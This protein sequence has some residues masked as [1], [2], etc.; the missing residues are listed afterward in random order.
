V[1]TTENG[2]RSAELFNKER[3]LRS[4]KIT[5]FVIFGM[6]TLW[7]GLGL[8]LGLEKMLVSTTPTFL[9]TFILFFL[10]SYG[11]RRYRALFMGDRV[12]CGNFHG[13]AFYRSGK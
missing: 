3:R 5:G 6:I 9:G 1:G 7:L 8:S 12:P 2:P 13:G 4:I 11:P 10:Y